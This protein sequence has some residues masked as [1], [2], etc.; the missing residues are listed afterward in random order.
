MTYVLLSGWYPVAQLEPDGEGVGGYEGGPQQVR[1][2]FCP[3]EYAVEARGEAVEATE[4][5]RAAR[6]AAWRMRE[7]GLRGIHAVPRRPGSEAW[8]EEP[9]LRL[10]RHEWV[11]Y[12]YR[13]LSRDAAIVEALCTRCRA[14]GRPTSYV[15]R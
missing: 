10:P 2:L 1:D 6:Y 14:V 8:T 7:D 9:Q 4:A 13:Q 3:P 12:Q 11:P 15:G 5:E